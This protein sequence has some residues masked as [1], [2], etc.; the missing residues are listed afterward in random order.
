[1]RHLIKIFPK[2][3]LVGLVAAV[4]CQ[5]PAPVKEAPKQEEVAKPEAAP[6]PAPEPEPVSEFAALRTAIKDWVDLLKRCDEGWFA[7]V[8]PSKIDN[9]EFPIDVDAMTS[10][11]Y[12]LRTGMDKMLE[13]GAFRNQQLDSFLR[14]AATA[15]DRYLI[16]SFRAKKISVKDKLP[17]KKELTALRDDLRA[18]VGALQKRAE[19]ILALA[20][21]DFHAISNAPASEVVTIARETLGRVRADFKAFVE[22]SIPTNKP[23]WRYSFKTTVALAKEAIS[24]LKAPRNGAPEAIAAPATALAQGLDSAV[25]YFGGEFFWEE[26]E[27]IDATRKSVVKVINAYDKAASKI[28]KK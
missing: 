16:M 10:F 9:Y 7:R 21:A 17:Y 8:D 28:F 5:K 4:A 26:D 20:D 24:A 15:T 23:V 6:A 1:M 18:E 13:L 11:C 12:D 22:D 14:E 19:Q 25:E 27:K 3:V 2:V